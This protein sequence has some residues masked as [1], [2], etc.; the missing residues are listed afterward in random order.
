MLGIVG[1]KTA[2]GNVITSIINMPNKD[3]TFW[4]NNFYSMARCSNLIVA[5]AGDITQRAQV[6]RN[7]RINEIALR[8]RRATDKLYKSGVKNTEFMYELIG[9]N[10]MIISDIDWQ[11][12]QTARNRE[13]R[14]LARL[15][16]DRYE[17]MRQLQDWEEANTE[18]RAVDV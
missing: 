9:D 16:L 8:I 4:D 14:R 15:N 17:F 10:W 12:Y 13:K 7:Q 6:A 11:A 2:D 18:E 5:A 3:I 1:D